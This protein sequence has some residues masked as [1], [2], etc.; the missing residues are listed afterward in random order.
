MYV[1]LLF[2]WLRN[3]VQSPQS[4]SVI[5]TRTFDKT[6]FL[7]ISIGLMLSSLA[8]VLLTQARR[9]IEM[10]LN[11]R[12][13]RWYSLHSFR[14]HARLDLATYSDAITR[15]RVE[16]SDNM[17]GQTIAYTSLELAT[18]ILSATAQMFT[19]VAVLLR[20]LHDQQNGAMLVALTLFVEALY[21]LPQMINFWKTRGA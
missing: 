10:P 17:C 5:D 21:W 8:N 4:E 3:D 20:I 11:A 2:S 12:L 18:S 19:S 16:N 9:H 7:S 14:V 1:T 15:Q 6:R 13:R